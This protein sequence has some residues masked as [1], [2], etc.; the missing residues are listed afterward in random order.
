MLKKFIPSFLAFAL[1][2][3]QAGAIAPTPLKALYDDVAFELAVR[4]DPKDAPGRE[5]AVDAFI[6][7]ARKLGTTNQ[8]LMAFALSEVRDESIRSELQ[9]IFAAVDSE[10]LNQAE[11]EQLVVEALIRSHA[12]GTSWEGESVTPGQ[13]ALFIGGLAAVF[14]AIWLATSE[15]EDASGGGSGTGTGAGPTCVRYETQYNTVCVEVERNPWCIQEN[16]CVPVRE[17]VCTQEPYTYCAEFA[18]AP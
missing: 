14:V 16:V 15:E 13:V 3:G 1:V 10:K 17:Q 5:A 9:G 12:K 18:P 4:L 8:G 2:T 6:E 11:L 7:G